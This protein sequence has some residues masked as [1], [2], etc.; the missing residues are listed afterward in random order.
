MAMEEKPTITAEMHCRKR[1]SSRAGKLVIIRDDGDH[2]NTHFRSFQAPMVSR[3]RGAGWPSA[4][5]AP[6]TSNTRLFPPPLTVNRFAPGPAIVVFAAS[7]STSGPAE[8]AMPCQL[9]AAILERIGRL[10][11]ACDSG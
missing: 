2:L 5:D 8:L 3:W 4:T 9:F 10:R 1:R 6:G 7:E 11:L